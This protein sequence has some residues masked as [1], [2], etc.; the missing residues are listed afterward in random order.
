MS[1]TIIENALCGEK[2]HFYEHK[3]GAK[4][5]VVEKPDF[6]SV[7]AYFGTKYGSIDTTFKTDTMKSFLTVPEGI[8]HYL[9]HKLFENEDCDAFER[10]AKTGAYA[11]AYTSFDSTC[12]LFN[13]SS[14]F[15]D[16]FKILLDFVQDPYFTEETV[17]K[18]QGI[19][20]QEINMY[21]DDPDW[22][23]FF[24]LL[25]NMYSNHPVRID[26]AGTVESISHITPQL[27]YDCYNTFYNLNNMFICVAGNVKA[28]TV[29]DICDEMLKNKPAVK[30]ERAK[31][32]EPSA[33]L[34]DYVEY[35][36]PVAMPL[37][38]IGYKQECKTA[39]K[40]V[41]E[42]VAASLINSIVFGNDSPLYKELFDSGLI[43]EE[44]GAQYFNGHYFAS[45]L[46]EGESK[47]PKKVKQIIDSHIK[48]LLEK[49]IDK[50]A[51]LRIKKA[52]IG[53]GISAYDEPSGI[54]RILVSAALSNVGPFDEL[55]MI[56]EIDYDFV[57]SYF[58]E[59]FNINNSTLSVVKSK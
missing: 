25:K 18:E 1:K 17:A 21:D 52:R 57:N 36:L 54:A 9:E 48:N 10:Y 38:A 55:N 30:I 44:F 16:S 14:N 29:F 27:L 43:N 3:T 42:V 8:A 49:G 53:A 31:I 20:G 51:F 2:C 58:K 5:M 22:S 11:N 28:E 46:I 24:N 39:E 13:C 7:S 45:T 34:N 6:S 15:E 35:N 40:S 23:V 47:E 37:F 50:D 33:V 4:I 32:S 12:Y 59:M 19:I 56:N 41:K 26:I